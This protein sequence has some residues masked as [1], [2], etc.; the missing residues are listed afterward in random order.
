MST[1]EAP[2]E[3]APAD[4]LD[5]P[6]AGP[7][8]IRGSALRA[9]AHVAGIGLAL[10]SAPLLIHHLGVEDWGRYVLVNSVVLIVGGVMDAGLISIAQRE[11]VVRTGAD[12]DRTMRNLL[13]LRLV[14]MSAA[15]ALA[16]G[17]AAVAGY[18]RD[19]VIGTV[20]S[21]VGLLL[22]A[23][24][25][26]LVTPLIAALRFGVT[27][28]MEF[29]GQVLMVA[30]VVALV[31]ADA[32]LLAFL[33]VGIPVAIVLTGVTAA[34]TRGQSPL[35]P[36]FDR[37]EW[38]ELVRDTLPYAAAAAVTAV[39][40][41]LSMVVLSLVSSDFETGL[42]ATS[43]RV[44][45]VVLGVPALLVSALFPVLARAAERDERRLASSVARIFEVGI[46]LGLGATLLLELSAP[47]VIDV[48][49]D[50]EAAGATDVLRL[51]APAVI[52][53]FVAVTCAFPLLSL[54]RHGSVLVANLVGL[55]G[56]VIGTLA[57]AP[58]FGAEGTAVATVIAEGLLALAM[59]VLLLRSRRSVRLPLGVVGPALA[60]A[61]LGACALLLP[62]HDAAR[63][64]IGGAV[65]FGGLL[66]LGRIPPE[67]LDAV[68]LR[69]AV[70]P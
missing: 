62:V 64:A 34:L 36:R 66:A 27:T 39:Y 40:F 24:Q 44:V 49:A 60:L 9:S 46:I 6:R 59:A 69:R 68:K 14:L 20:I 15:V 38:W 23:I 19:V 7:A 52:A 56:S 21:G 16:V 51:Q 47:F 30:L 18:D 70:T 37:V 33:A 31:V 58:A 8:A 28:A 10:V 32:G 13:G 55:G 11:Y 48:L 42:Y 4:V 45:E 29:A 43:Y 1:P 12:R 26:M 53:T 22:L 5:T 54:R 35:R 63:A 25:H 50:D 61:A 57:L 67:L 3:K 65:Y 17:F 2:L 41:R